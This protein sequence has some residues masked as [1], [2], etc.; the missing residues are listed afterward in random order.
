MLTNRHTAAETFRL[1][2]KA[3]EVHAALMRAGTKPIYLKGASFSSLLYPDRGARAYGDIDLLVAPRD[4][5]DAEA[6]LRHLGFRR[7]DPF[8][9][10]ASTGTALGVAVGTAGSNHGTAWLRD[11]DNL[12]V[13]LHHSLPQVGVDADRLWE[14]L[15]PH[16]TSMVRAGTEF[17]VLDDQAS[18][19]LLTLHAAHNGPEDAKSLEDLRRGTQL[20][21]GETWRGA[22]ELA[23]KLRAVQSMGIGLGLCPRGVEIAEQ[24]G[25]STQPPLVVQMHWRGAPW[26]TT[27]IQALSAGPGYRARMRLIAR[28]VAPPA[29]AMRAGSPLAKR[30]GI[31]L[32]VAYGVRLAAIIR[33]T[34]GA[35]L[36]WHRSQSARG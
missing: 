19:L 16:R 7:F 13:D 33:R 30:G 20:L 23:Q 8:S 24:L 9:L 12:A 6:A 14:E 29:E 31:G 27:F 25:V 2:L 5:S 28:L 26:A 21:S 35:L 4:L 17:P 10:S 34:P 15:Q 3:H 11:R 32:P 36:A 18:A 22:L 1:D